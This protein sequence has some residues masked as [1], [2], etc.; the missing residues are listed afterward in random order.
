MRVEINKWER[1]QKFC[2][3]KEIIT[4]TKRHPTEWEEKFANDITDKQLYSNYA[5]SSSNSIPK[6]CQ[7]IHS[8]LSRRP[9]S[10]FFS[11][12][13]CRW[14]TGTWKDVQHH[15]L[16]EKC[17]SKPQTRIMGFFAESFHF[18]LRFKGCVKKISHKLYTNK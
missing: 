5:N 17:K 16:L 14:P 7:T 12:K 18:H 13:I 9:K 3:T 1:I 15:K 11:R 4:K 6:Q 8:K 2:I 10:T